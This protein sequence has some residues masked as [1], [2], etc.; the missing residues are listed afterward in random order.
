MKKVKK[1]IVYK[2][3]NLINSHFYIGIHGTENPDIFDGYLANGIKVNSPSSYKNPT[4]P[5]QYAVNKYGIEN[6]KREVLFIYD[7]VQEALNK[8]GE[9]VDKE[10]IKRKDTYNV[11]LGGNMATHFIEIY[12]FDNKGNFL[13]KWDSIVD[14]ADYYE[15]TDGAIVNSIRYKGSCRGFL[16]SK[17][18][19]INIEDYSYREHTP[20]YKYSC[21][22]TFIEEYW[23]CVEAAKANN[24][25][26][27][28]VMR[29]CKGEY[30]I[31]NEY[32]LYEVYDLFV[33]NKKKVNLRNKTIYL[34]NLNGDYV[35]EFSN[36]TEACQFFNISTSSN[37]IS[38]AIRTER[39]YKGYQLRLEKYDKITAVEMET[40]SSKPVL[41]FDLNGNLIE[42]F[43]SMSKAIKKYGTGVQKVLYGNQKQC[44][45]FIFK[46]K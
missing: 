30:K 28:Q 25:T 23:S 6:F 42:E 10:F 39:Q 5:M 4:T 14:A 16:W 26:K 35:R 18:S 8:E 27:S 24:T 19:T 2:T 21:D 3:T 36:R 45:G 43:S 12:Q 13:K 7:T 31:N 17:E 15:V 40:C 32:Y 44:K 1:Y 46:Y 20:V 22:G 38:T 29:A 41:C 33:P 11:A 9:I 34:Y 37:S